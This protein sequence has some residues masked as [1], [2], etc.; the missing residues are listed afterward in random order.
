MTEQER[1]NVE[2]QTKLTVHDE[3]FDAFMREMQDF[4]NEMR[5]KDNQRHAEIMEIRNTVDSTNKHISNFFYTS[6]VAIGA[7]LLTVILNL[8]KG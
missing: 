4:K 6:L 8:P 7:M 1:I 2:V 3:K 5:D